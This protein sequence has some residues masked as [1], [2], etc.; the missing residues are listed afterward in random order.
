MVNGQH[1]QEITVWN[2]KISLY[3]QHNHVRG[4][5]AIYPRDYYTLKGYHILEMYTVKG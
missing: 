2:T 5:W 4:K 3:G 1:F